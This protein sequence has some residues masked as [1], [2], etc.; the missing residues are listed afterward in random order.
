MQRWIGLGAVAAA[1]AGALIWQLTSEPADSYAF[2]EGPDFPKKGYDFDTS[3]LAI[4][5][6]DGKQTF[7]VPT[8]QDPEWEDYLEMKKHRPF[9]SFMDGR[10]GYAIP[11][12]PEWRALVRGYRDAEPVDYDLIDTYSSLEDLANDVLRAIREEDSQFLREMHIRM[13]EFETLCWPSFPQSRPYVRIP[14]SEAW[15]F[16]FAS[17]TS[18][19]M[20]L[21]QKHG[22][23]D[24]VLDRV[25]VGKRLEYPPNFALLTDVKIVAHDRETGQLTTIDNVQSVIEQKNQFKVFVFKD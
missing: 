13:E 9:Q 19:L 16:H 21:V 11:Y 14:V 22:K 7:T 2:K 8:P 23:K 5:S 10:E 18:G 17:C 12:D 15:G 24:L 20:D 25:E 3:H 1:V 6:R 4:E